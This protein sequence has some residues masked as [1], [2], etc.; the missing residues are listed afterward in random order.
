MDP[1]SDSDPGCPKTYGSDG[2]G[3]ATLTVTLLYTIVSR[4]V[5]YV[6]VRWRRREPR[7]TW[8]L[9]Y[10]DPDPD[11]D[12]SKCLDPDSVKSENCSTALY[13]RKQRYDLRMCQVEGERAT[14]H[15]IQLTGRRGEAAGTEK[16]RRRK[17]KGDE[18][19]EVGTSYFMSTD[20]VRMVWDFL[21]L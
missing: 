19:E 1:D 3:S 21:Y 6:C 8:S 9:K 4:D 18:E 15:L 20:S 5:I 7:G 13:N 10:P 14:W 17:E 12:S 11:Q 2:S 16:R